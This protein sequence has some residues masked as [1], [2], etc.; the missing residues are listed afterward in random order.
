MNLVAT[1]PISGGK[2][3]DRRERCRLQSLTALEIGF[4]AGQFHQ[5][6]FHQDGHGGIHFGRFNSRTTKDFAVE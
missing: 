4:R 6:F 2:R 3:L 1:Q 5:V